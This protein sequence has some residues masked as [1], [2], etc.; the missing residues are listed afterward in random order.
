MLAPITKG[1]CARIDHFRSVGMLAPDV[2]YQQ[3]RRILCNIKV[4]TG[5][6][7]KCGQDSEYGMSY[8]YNI[9]SFFI[10]NRLIIEIKWRTFTRPQRK[11]FTKGLL[12]AVL[13]EFGES[14]TNRKYRK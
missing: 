7:E 5:S 6:G 13:P 1:L 8:N 3:Y 11:E 2:A 4:D 14:T 9:H 10:D 12:C